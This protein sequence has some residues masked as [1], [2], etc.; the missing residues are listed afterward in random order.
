MPHDANRLVTLALLA[1]AA[2]ALDDGAQPAAARMA[3]EPY[4]GRRPV[5]G[6]GG[7]VLDPV[8]ETLARLA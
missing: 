6:Y 8:D 5:S 1:E 7:L 2:L 4:A 3:L